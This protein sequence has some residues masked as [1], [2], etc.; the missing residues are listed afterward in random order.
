VD[1][2]DEFHDGA[3]KAQSQSCWKCNIKQLQSGIYSEFNILVYH[4]GYVSNKVQGC[5]VS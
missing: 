4:M 2:G 5:A 3:A 1:S